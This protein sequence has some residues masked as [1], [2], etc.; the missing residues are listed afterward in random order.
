MAA[1]QNSVPLLLPSLLVPGSQR[2]CPVG[3]IPHPLAVPESLYDTRQCDD[4]GRAAS[5]LGSTVEV[6]PRL[7][8]PAEDD[9]DCGASGGTPRPR[10]VASRTPA[11]RIRTRSSVLSSGETAT[12]VSCDDATTASLVLGP[13]LQNSPEARYPQGLQQQEG[14]TSQVGHVQQQQHHHPH[15]HHPHFRHHQQQRASSSRATSSQ[16]TTPP[17]SSPPSFSSSQPL[18]PDVDLDSSC[19]MCLEG[20][21]NERRCALSGTPEETCSSVAAPCCCTSEV[22]AGEADDPRGGTVSATCMKSSSYSSLPGAGAKPTR[23]KRRG[24]STNPNT[25]SSRGN[26]VSSAERWSCAIR[27]PWQ[28][29]AEELMEEKAQKKARVRKLLA[30]ERR[31][32]EERERRERESSAL[33]AAGLS[34]VSLSVLCAP[35]SFSAILSSC[36]THLRVGSCSSVLLAL[37]EGYCSCS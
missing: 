20:L 28:L 21:A 23:R 33:M 31:L 25:P 37:G 8:G 13:S 18:S 26:S 29:S 34:C 12:T 14:H 6:E 30:L 19:S 36:V 9:S 24:T 2:R 1:Q 7:G 27:R 32:N 22:G 4:E 35:F 11:L 15:H 16:W 17:M 5:T 10:T 3:S